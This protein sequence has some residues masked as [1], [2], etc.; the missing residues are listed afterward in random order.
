MPYFD[1]IVKARMQNEEMRNVWCVQTSPVVGDLPLQ[2][3]ADQ[4]RDMYNTHWRPHSSG[5]CTIYEI[6]ARQV[7]VAGMPEFS[8]NTS[9]VVG[10]LSAD[11]FPRAISG[12]LKLRSMTARPNRGSKYIFGATEASSD[13]NGRPDA[14]YRNALFAFGQAI[15]DFNNGILDCQF[16]IPR[17]TVGGTVV[18]SNDIT[19]FAA[20]TEWAFQRRRQNGR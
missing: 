11:P 7:D 18:D 13:A 17:R 3:A 9:P 4:L 5:L 1:L 12:Y 14:N 10:A 19:L 6:A 15:V 2:E 8:L 16:V 20:G